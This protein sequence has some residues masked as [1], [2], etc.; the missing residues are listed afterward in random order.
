MLQNLQSAL[1]VV[2]ILGFA[3]LI[4]E[5]RRAVPWRPVAV[6][7]VVT[8]A[9]ALLMLKVPQTAI[10]FDWINRGVEALAAATKAGT[11]FVFG[12][13]GGGPLPFAAK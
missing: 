7:L 3:F 12:Y 6:G 2:A 1:G 5:N 11:A 10:V 13:V 8:F 9:L 4:S